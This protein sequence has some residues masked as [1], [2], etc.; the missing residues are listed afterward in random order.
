MHFMSVFIAAGGGCVINE[1]AYG[2]RYERNIHRGVVGTGLV[3]R[4]QV[5]EANGYSFVVSIDAC[6]FS[7][8]TTGL[9]AEGANCLSIRNTVVQ[10]CTDGIVIDPVANGVVAFNIT[11]ENVWMENNA[12]WD[13]NLNSNVSSWCE[14]SIRRC[15]FGRG[16][17]NTK[18]NLGTK[19]RIVVE[20]IAA[21]PGSV[22]VTG[23]GSASFTG[24]NT[25]PK[26]IQN[27]SFYWIVYNAAGG[28]D[29]PFL[30]TDGS[31]NV[32]TKA[33]AFVSAAGFKSA[34]G[35]VSVPDATAT[36]LFTMP[37]S[38]NAVYM[39]T[40]TAGISGPAA[41]TVV[42]IVACS[43]SL[44]TLT[45]LKTSSNLTLSLSGLNVQGTHAV[46]LTVEVSTTVTRIQ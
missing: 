16:A 44:A 45:V 25:T 40:T 31:F 26:Y 23:S 27:G 9:Y 22:E 35:S 38:T 7:F 43:E 30:S 14:A 46:G 24:V 11:L 33:G 3:L 41:W 36:T 42:A 5:V 19:S 4:Q 15:Q 39:L 2:L 13:I 10:A 12:G 37:S 6:D 32:I 29:T 21:G 20:G 18:I 17:S 28:F 8:C 34:S 1:V